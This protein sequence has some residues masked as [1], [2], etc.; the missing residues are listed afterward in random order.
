M[1]RLA[2]VSFAHIHAWSYARVVKEL[3]ARGRAV[4]EAIYD[5]DPERLKK[6]AETYRPRKVYDSF[7]KL[8]EDREID[9]T[10]V[11][12]ENAKHARF[13]IPLMES[14]RHVIVEKPIATTYRDAKEMVDTARR[15]G[16][17]LQVAF[18]MRYHDASVEIKNR[19]GALGRIRYITATNHGR[20]PFSWFVDPELAGGGAMMDHIVHVADLIRWYTGK[21]FEEV[22]AFVG[23]NIYPELKVEDNA[24]LIARLNDGTPVSIDCSWSRPKTWPIWGDVYMHIVGEKGALI[25][26]AF[27]QNIS[28]ANPDGFT[29]YY[30]GPDA[31]LNMVEDFVDCIEKDREPRATGEDG[32]RALEVVLAAYRSWREGR[33]VK[34]SDIRS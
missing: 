27:N 32:L 17:K 25:L 18:V 34:V 9:A 24:L 20:C 23:R 7:E 33:P 29:W 19:I 2:I 1:I 14:G 28:L 13:A 4:L 6:A 15:R 16:V 26:N 5:D 10:I 8:L 12:S 22:M 21:E 3:E 30:F 31:D 11:A